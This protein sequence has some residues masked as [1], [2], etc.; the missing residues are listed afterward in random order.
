LNNKVAFNKVQ[1]YQ[2]ICRV[3]PWRDP[4]KS[5]FIKCRATSWRGLNF[6]DTSKNSKDRSEACLY[7]N[8][9][10]Y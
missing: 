3:M 6:R 1:I 7:N 10:Y 8:Q 4:T 5:S 2:K 9:K